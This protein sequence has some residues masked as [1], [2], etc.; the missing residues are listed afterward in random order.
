MRAVL[1]LCGGVLLLKWSVSEL[2][3]FTC[4]KLQ[5]HCNTLFP[6]SFVVRKVWKNWNVSPTWGFDHFAYSYTTFGHLCYIT[7]ILYYFLGKGHGT[8]LFCYLASCLNL[9]HIIAMSHKTSGDQEQLFSF[10]EQ[11]LWKA[12]VV[13]WYS[14]VRIQ[15]CH[16]SRVPERIQNLSLQML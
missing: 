4:N 9:S 7:Y 12:T 16:K 14:V 10:T 13:L 3:K 8:N 6:L 5:A 1:C 15:L 2:I 11:C